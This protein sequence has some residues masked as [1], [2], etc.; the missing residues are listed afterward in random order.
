M[1]LLHAV[2]VLGLRHNMPLP[3][4]SN[5][6]II[7]PAK[8][9]AASIAQVIADIRKHFSGTILVVNDASTDDTATIARQASAHVLNLSFSLG[10]WGAMQTGLRYAQQHNYQI[11]ITMDADGQHRADTLL[12]LLL[13]LEAE[14]AD[15]IIGAF[16]QRGSAARQFAWSLFRFLSG[17][18]QEDLTSGLRAYNH[19]AIS[20]LASSK[21]TLLDYQDLGV[22]LL[23]HTEKLQVMETPIEMRER[24][25][26][27]S[28]IFSS[29]WAVG[30]Y[31]VYT[32]TL[33]IARGSRLPIIK[34]RH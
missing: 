7:I 15:V 30:K 18:T 26:G 28:R 3:D 24:A 25:D 14:E 34:H 21:A 20:L 27:K 19:Q 11:A 2:F 4:N 16:T 9:E 33:C 8:N 5:L 22:L 10:A 6:I 32:A 13:P 29:W 12:N 1:P 23:L 31:M 17:I